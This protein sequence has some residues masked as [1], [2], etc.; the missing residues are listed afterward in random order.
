MVVLVLHDVIRII[1]IILYW[2]PADS[3]NV[4]TVSAFS[5][6]PVHN[7]VLKFEDM[8]YLPFCKREIQCG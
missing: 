5:R 2:A 8:I 6:W 3:M 7:F 1:C 4:L